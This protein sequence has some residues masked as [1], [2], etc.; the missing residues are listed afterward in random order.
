[1]KL[2]DWATLHIF[3]AAIECGSVTRA[4][5]NCCIAFSAVAK[6]IQDLETVLGVQLL[7]R[8]ARGVTPAVAGELLAWHQIELGYALVTKL[9]MLF[10]RTSGAIQGET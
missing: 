2:P 5:E 1:M 6:R 7:T 8:G 10:R 3:L 9:V 4:S